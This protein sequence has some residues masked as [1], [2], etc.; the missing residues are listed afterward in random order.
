LIP[1]PRG[2]RSAPH[3]RE[4]LQP[5]RLSG[6]KLVFS[7]AT[8]FAFVSPSPLPPSLPHPTSL[9][10]SFFVGGGGGGGGSPAVASQGSSGSVIR[11]TD[12]LVRL[13][14]HPRSRF[15]IP[16]FV[17]RCLSI[18][19]RVARSPDAP[20]SESTRSVKGDF[21][22]CPCP[23]CLLPISWSTA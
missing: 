9:S 11:R 1:V 21:V 7:P 12:S 19:N 23:E 15:I 17:Q 18:D 22:R 3:L 13:P 5:A 8:S 16:S 2:S 4:G 14:I 10:G 20:A 6:Q